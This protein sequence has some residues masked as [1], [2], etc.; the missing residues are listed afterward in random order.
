MT[1]DWLIYIHDTKTLHL[2]I[3]CHNCKVYCFSLKAA[4]VCL[5]LFTPTVTMT[6]IIIIIMKNFNRC[7]SHGYHGSKRRELT[8][9]IH[10]H[11][12]HAFTHTLI[13]TQFAP[14]QLL[15]F[16]ACWVVSCFH[17]PPNHDMDYRI[18]IIHAYVSILVSVCWAY[19]QRVGT[20]FWL[21]KTLTN[22]TCA[23]DG[24]W[25]LDLKADALPIEPP[26]MSPL[27]TWQCKSISCVK[28]MN[29]NIIVDN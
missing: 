22:F 28:L 2:C 16:S 12:S 19:W 13:L 29:H 5:G 11:G 10:S 21:G 3:L 23:P 6:I 1:V 4:A 20:T 18:F 24:I 27:S 25:P 7:D 15:F 8:Q 26:C 17:N 9:H 14:A